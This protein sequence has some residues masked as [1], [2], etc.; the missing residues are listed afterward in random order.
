MDI[1]HI[2]GITS[3]SAGSY[4]H[5]IYSALE[6][7]FTQDII[8]NYYYPYRYGKKV[9]F[10]FSD[11][12]NSNFFHKINKLRLVIRYFEMMFGLMY[13]LFFIWIKKPKII[14]YSL[15]SQINIEY[16]FLF[17]ISKYSKSKLFLTVHDVIPFQTTFTNQKSDIKKR[18]SFFNLADKLIVHNKNSINDL[19]K[20]YNISSS[21]IIYHLFPVMDIS[22]FNYEKDKNYELE[23]IFTKNNFIFSFVGHLRKEKGIEVLLK[24]WDIFTKEF[25]THKS[26]LVIAGNIP[27]GFKYNFNKYTNIILIDKFLSDFE[28]KEIIIKSDCIILPYTMGTN[29]GIPS[30]VLSLKT[31]LITSDIDMFLNNEFIDKQYIFK[32]KNSKS[33]ALIMN[34]I[35]K[36]K[37][38]DFSKIKNYE[39]LV[40]KSI[41]DLYQKELKEI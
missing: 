4:M 31:Q 11:L 25:P 17:I 14:N 28:Y 5:K 7:Q 40:K 37:N 34:N 36:E 41:F 20:Y 38:Y 35:L 26:Q 10:K 15:T 19:K 3:G 32:N 12:S 33:L 6:K 13:S 18:K 22:E 16:I 21:K 2:Y 24:A 27:K 9:F 30:T 39:N 23:K 8:V 29:S 1:L